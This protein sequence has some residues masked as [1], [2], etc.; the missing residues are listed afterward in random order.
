MIVTCSAGKYR[1]AD[2]TDDTGVFGHK[3]VA[4]NNKQILWSIP[5]TPPGDIIHQDWNTNDIR[6]TFTEKS[7]GHT[8]E[9]K[10]GEV[11]NVRKNEDGRYEYLVKWKDYPISQSTYE[12]ESNLR[13]G[14]KET[15]DKY[16][17]N[18]LLD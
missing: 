11:G 4:S 5:K 18:N 2:G 14:A 8:F 3:P 13:V 9:I 17:Y 6:F 7:G 1:S 16:K 10:G 15:L 12:D